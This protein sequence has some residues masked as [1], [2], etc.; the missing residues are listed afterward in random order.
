MRP[1]AID[2][3]TMRSGTTQSDA[4]RATARLV[5]A[6]RDPIRFPHPTSRVRVIETHISYIV[7][8]GS[9]AYKIKKPLRLDFLDFTSLASR[10]SACEDELRLNRR[11]APD[12]Y[13]RVAA[14]TGSPDAPCFD[15]AGDPIE[16]A[17]EM[18]QFDPDALLATGLSRGEIT[19]ETVDALAERIASFHAEL[20]LAPDSP[21]VA[22]RGRRRGDRAQERERDPRARARA[23]VAGARRGARDL[24]RGRA[25][26]RG[27]AARRAPAARDSCAS[28]TA[29]SIWRTSP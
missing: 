1:V 2:P 4:A 11:T 14:I 27:S 7:L 26:P 18:R 10:R 17:V 13:L 22:D 3:P 12:L 28:V 9:R 29:I 20:A 16:Y 8:T 25:R 5:E 24:D 23:R 19:G 15:G 21:S 6:L